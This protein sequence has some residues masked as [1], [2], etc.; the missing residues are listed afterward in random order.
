MM[1]NTGAGNR[2]SGVKVSSRM[3]ILN[4]ICAMIMIGVWLAGCG[5]GSGGGGKKDPAPT[6]NALAVGVIIQGQSDE[7][8]GSTNR[9]SYKVLSSPNRD[10]KRIDLAPGYRKY[11]AQSTA[12]FRAA[13]VTDEFLTENDALILLAWDAVRGAEQYQVFYNNIKVWDSADAH[14]AD[15]DYEP[16]N[17]QAYLDLDDELKDKI[18][19]AGADYKFQI[20]ALKGN[21]V[22]TRLPEVTASLGMI[23]E[24]ITAVFNTTIPNLTWSGVANAHE[25]KL[26][27]FNG[28]KYETS[29]FGFE[30][31]ISATSYDVS[32]IPSISHQYHHVWVDARNLDANGNPEEIT[33]GIG[34]FNY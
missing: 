33:R 27:I 29:T 2:E 31:K 7:V 10:L 22:I 1:K 30:D 13:A 3:A 4:I 34:G 18:T 12:S 6:Y 21:T 11:V 32:A 8:F 19:T 28:N 15:P 26:T 23:L 16:S 5:G 20:L 24:T 17:P 25:Y 14:D 9:N